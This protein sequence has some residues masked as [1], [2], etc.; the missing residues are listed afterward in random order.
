MH[1]L[2]FNFSVP[3]QFG[4]GVYVKWPLV[5]NP[6]QVKCKLNNQWYYFDVLDEILKEKMI[7][8]H[9]IHLQAVI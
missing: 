7:K 8:I 4:F 1:E 2:D 9:Y 3:F 5:S 6:T